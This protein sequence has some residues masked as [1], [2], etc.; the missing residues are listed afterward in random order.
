MLKLTPLAKAHNII[1]VLIDNEKVPDYIENG[2]IFDRNGKKINPVSNIRLAV[3]LHQVAPDTYYDNVYLIDKFRKIAWRP[4]DQNL[5]ENTALT[6][7]IVDNVIKH[8]SLHDIVTSLF[9]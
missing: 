4:H 6:K 3:S 1:G 8:H 9:E 7:A 2:E 5:P